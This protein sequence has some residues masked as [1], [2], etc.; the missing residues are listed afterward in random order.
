M[1]W[2]NKYIYIAVRSYSVLLFYFFFH[3]HCSMFLLS[4][5]CNFAGYELQ[6]VGC[7]SAP[8]MST[9]S[10]NSQD[11]RGSYTSCAKMMKL[12]IQMYPLY[13]G[14]TCAEVAEELWWFL[15]DPCRLVRFSGFTGGVQDWPLS[16]EEQKKRIIRL[17]DK[18][19]PWF[20]SI[21]TCPVR[22]TH[23]GIEMDWDDED[24]VEDS[25]RK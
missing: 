20:W 9:T 8:A 18:D 23:H 6:P 2:L 17:Y 10:S 13:N 22:K 4:N 16:K 19:G 3:S 1:D 5:T 11:A 24:V 12:T 21:S 25:D 14:S 7:S 15:D